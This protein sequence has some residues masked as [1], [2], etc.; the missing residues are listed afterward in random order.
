MVTM[1]PL[2]SVPPDMD[3][4]TSTLWSVTSTGVIAHC[5]L[6]PGPALGAREN[7][8]EPGARFRTINSFPQGTEGPKPPISG[9]VENIHF[10]PSAQSPGSTKR[11]AR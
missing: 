8:Y 1:R 5:I 3:I 7:E 4:A 9:V 2:M 6:E 10:S 11:C